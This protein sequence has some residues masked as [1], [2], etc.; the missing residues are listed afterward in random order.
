MLQ[1]S[2]AWAQICALKTVVSEPRGTGDSFDSCMSEYYAAIKSGR[3]G[4]MMAVCRGKVGLCML[5][6][7]FADC[8]CLVLLEQRY[9]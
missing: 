9:W 1:A 5:R 8:Y 4:L 3:G 2:G 6:K 7:V